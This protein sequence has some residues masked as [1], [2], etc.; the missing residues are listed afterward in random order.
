MKI[1]N[2]RIFGRIHRLGLAALLTTGLAS[3]AQ[4]YLWEGH[5]DVGV[6]FEDGEWDLHVGQHEAD[7]PMEYEPGEV[8]LGVDIVA[9][10]QTV[11]S[12]SEFSF[13]GAPGS[14]VWILPQAHQSGLLFLGF[15]AEELE[16]GAFVNDQVTLSLQAVRGTGLFSVYTVDMFGSPSVLMDSGDGI[17]GADAISLSAGAHQHVNWAFST[18]G[19]YEVDFEATGTL[20]DGNVFTS[21]GLVTYT[22]DVAAVPEPGTLALVALGSLG[23]LWRGRRNHH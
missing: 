12:V 21:S 19:L 20:T 7:P 8:V 1:Q 4:T 13:L 14:S 11:P 17:T 6:A 9:A 23:L 3:Q 2:N 10:Q 16:E 22:F 5:T 15:G 18:P